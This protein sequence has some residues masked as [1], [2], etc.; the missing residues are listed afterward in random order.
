MSLWT[1]CVISILA[2]NSLVVVTSLY[3]HFRNK[4][5]I[6]ETRSP[7]P[8]P[9]QSLIPFPVQNYDTSKPTMTQTREVT[10]THITLPGSSAVAYIDDESAGMEAQDSLRSLRLTLTIIET[11]L[12][13]ASSDEGPLHAERRP[14]RKAA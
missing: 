7:T 8:H 13:L 10:N 1:Q 14:C 3:R 9:P 5:D 11:D 4:A 2:C 6:P 12:S